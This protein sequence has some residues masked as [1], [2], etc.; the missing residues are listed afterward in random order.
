MALK[1]AKEELAAFTTQQGED[2]KKL[3]GIV[4][5]LESTNDFGPIGEHFMLFGNCF[6]TKEQKYVLKLIYK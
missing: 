3:A 6:E 2:T 4:A 1:N 5:K